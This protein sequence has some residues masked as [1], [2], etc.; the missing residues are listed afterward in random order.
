M[1]SAAAVLARMDRAMRQ[2]SGDRIDAVHV[3]RRKLQRE[4]RLAYGLMALT[5]GVL[6]VLAAPGVIVP[7]FSSWAT[8]LSILAGVAAVAVLGRIA[9]GGMRR[10]IAVLEDSW[11]ATPPVAPGEPA[12]C[13]VCGGPVVAGDDPAVARC[14][15]CG[16][17]NLVDHDVLERVARASSAVV[18]NL[19]RAIE[20]QASSLADVMGETH[21]SLLALLVTI[22]IV[23]PVFTLASSL[24]V[25]S[26]ETPFDSSARYGFGKSYGT[27]CACVHPARAGDPPFDPATLVA[28]KDCHYGGKV[29]RLVG[30]PL[31]GNHAV[32]VVGSS[33]Y[34][35]KMNELCVEDDVPARR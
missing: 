35:R 26:I 21:T 1:A 33:S 18:T 8:P 28:K 19:D 17:D 6:V 22:P 12:A 20:E 14:P 5:S 34:D 27:K 32:V 30:N 3:A 29:E 7:T 24:V 13:H 25:G 4:R 23:A 15:Y 9:L 10:R 16:A 31:T 11:A 2:L